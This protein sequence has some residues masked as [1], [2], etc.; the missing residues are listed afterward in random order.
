MNLKIGLTEKKHGWQ[1]IL[2]QEGVPTEIISCSNEIKP[3]DASLIVVSGFNTSPQ[4]KNIL[5]YVRSGGVVLVDSVMS[6][7]LLNIKTKKR[8]IQYLI[9]DVDSIYSEIGLVDIDQD[10]KLPK[11][12]DIT[13]LDKG[14]KI[15]TMKIGK[16]IVLILPFNVNKAI[17]DSTTARHKFYFKRKE[18]PSERVAKVS[19]GEIRKIVRISLE[20][21]HHFRNL[22]FIQL[23]YYPNGE[24]NVFLFRVDTD[25][26]SKEEAKELFK[27]CETNNI[28]ASWFIETKSSE[29]WI[30]DF[31]KMRNQEIGLHCFWHRVFKDYQS[32][33]ENIEKGLK[34]LKKFGTIPI[35]FVAPYGEWN[36]NLARAIEESGFEYSSEF[37]LDYDDLPFYPYSENKFSN[38]LQIPTYPICIGRL[39]RS[40]FSEEEMLEYFKNIINNKI[41][42]N[43]P[44]ILYHHPIHKHFLILDKIF[45]I[46]NKKNI[47]KMNFLEYGHWWKAR[48][49]LRITARMNRNKI[50]IDTNRDYSQSVWV[51]ISSPKGYCI[52]PINSEIEMYKINWETK[53]K[54]IK[55]PN[56]LSRVKKFHWRD[57]LYN[58]ESLK[59]KLEPTHNDE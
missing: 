55:F 45:Q 37:C 5:E 3:S 57:W 59:S 41:Q 24:Q 23:W 26:C 33:Y 39:I 49:K 36:Y 35:G 53:R 4:K 2:G 18:L 44:I 34:I 31:K 58:I 14:L 19:K 17:L 48:T 16:G 10:C 9:P 20:F 12:K 47:L 42:F 13:S 21:L 27:V 30:A 32:N 1:I 6:P 28:S 7:K 51:R 52:L 29:K 38:V 50:L 11:T 22:P 56:N 25:F 40:H 46:I 54:N 43:E 8:K 15:Y